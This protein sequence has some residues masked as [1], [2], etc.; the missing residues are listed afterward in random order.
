[1]RFKDDPKSWGEK[2]L[3]KWRGVEW[4]R[5][6]WLLL[7]FALSLFADSF[8]V[9]LSRDVDPGRAGDGMLFLILGFRAASRSELPL[10]V[11][12]AGG[13]LTALALA[14]NHGMRETPR[15]LWAIVG[16]FLIAFVM[17]GGR[18][19]RDKPAEAEKP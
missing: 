7:A 17:F 1:M 10:S 5:S 8:L 11:V 14:L 18:R 13:C 6:R 12:V 3:P 16:I 9:P 15:F 4:T 19:R 2:L